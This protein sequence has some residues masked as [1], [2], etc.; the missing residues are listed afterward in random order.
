MEFIIG[1]GTSVITTGEKKTARVQ[2]PVSGTITDWVLLSLDDTSGSVTLDIW[3]DTYA[4]YP[5]TVGDTITAAAK[6]SIT[7]AT[8]NAS[9]TLTGW[10]TSITGGDIFSVNVDS[11]TSL[12]VIKLII[13]YTV[14]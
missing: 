2:V 6:P 5:P 7:T 11:V 14:S 9:S 12:K 4:N 1:D 10:T 8:K 13:K 3:K